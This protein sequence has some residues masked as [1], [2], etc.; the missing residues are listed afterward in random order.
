MNPRNPHPTIIAQVT[1]TDLHENGT[2]D[3]EYAVPLDPM[4]DRLAIPVP[5]QVPLRV[6]EGP[7]FRL[8]GT[9]KHTDDR[10]RP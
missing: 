9:E 2:T 6:T 5:G 7:L 3:G 8:L 10:L 4:G 1:K